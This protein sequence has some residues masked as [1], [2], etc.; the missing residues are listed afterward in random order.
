MYEEEDEEVVRDALAQLNGEKK[1]W[2]LERIAPEVKRRGHNCEGLSEEEK[3]CVVR[4]EMGDGMGQGFFVCLFRRE[5]GVE[6]SEEE[7]KKREEAYEKKVNE[8]SEKRVSE[9]KKEVK[10]E[11]KKKVVKTEKKEKKE[12]EKEKEKPVDYVARIRHYHGK[13]VPL[14]KSCWCVC[15]RNKA[16]QRLNHLFGRHVLIEGAKVLR[17]AEKEVEKERQHIMNVLRF[18]LTQLGCA[19][20]HRNDD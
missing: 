9:K 14:G 4:C 16:L 11:G 7:R 6:M 13:R 20:E 12:K 1:E 18:V 19:V 15:G 10:K 2:R 5:K 3:E 17:V 8:G